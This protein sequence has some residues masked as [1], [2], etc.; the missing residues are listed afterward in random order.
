[1][2]IGKWENGIIKDYVKWYN[3]AIIIVIFLGIIIN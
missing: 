3:I 2:N 1:M